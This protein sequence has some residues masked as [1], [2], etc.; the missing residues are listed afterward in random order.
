MKN[1]KRI[2]SL[3]A[4]FLVFVICF[5]INV[6][7]QEKEEFQAVDVD[8]N[9]FLATYVSYP[10]DFEKDFISAIKN[11]KSEINVSKYRI[12]GSNI[13]AVLYEICNK[14]PEYFYY[15]LSGTS[16]STFMNRVAVIRLEYYYSESKCKDMIA[17]LER[18]VKTPL[19]QVEK[20]N[21]DEEKFL[22]IHDYIATH[23]TYDEDGLSG[24][25]DL[26]DDISFTAYGC[27]VLN[28]SVCQG[29]S[30]AFIL[31]CKRAELLS[32]FVSSEPLC[33]AWNMVKIDDKYYHLDITWDDNATNSGYDFIELNGYVSHKYF[34]KSDDQFIESGHSKSGR[35]DWDTENKANDSE[36]YNNFYWENVDSCIFYIGA[37]SYYIKDGKLIKRDRYSGS[38]ET[39]Y[40]IPNKSGWDYSY[41]KLAYDYTTN[42]LFINEYDGIYAYNADSG[43]VFKVFNNSENGLIL[44]IAFFGDELKYDVV[45]NNSVVATKTASIV[46]PTSEKIL[47]DINDSGEFD[48]NDILDLK[49]ALAGSFEGLNKYNA[50]M[51][52]DGEINTADLLLMRKQYVEWT[53][54]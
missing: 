37:Y 35:I 17:Q 51:N 38:I 1:K 3:I 20:L 25:V 40:V 50:D 42:Y 45:K 8:E 33:H 19:E 7:A 39:A 4:V 12:Y 47:G 36:S 11:Y 52:A 54:F 27:L 43:D 9:Q 16:Y 30:D 26:V 53:L 13:S 24:N 44:G 32:Y 22:F 5:S 21:N 10:A 18:A 41:S 29:M 14:Y 49:Q 34:F 2:K 31:L 6:N 15:D 28:K 48:I 46:F 23:N